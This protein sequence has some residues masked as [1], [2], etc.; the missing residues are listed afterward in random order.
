MRDLSVLIFTVFLTAA[1]YSAAYAASHECEGSNIS[2]GD[3]KCISPEWLCDR[4]K[5]CVDGSDERNCT[6][7]CKEDEFQCDAK[8]CIS[9]KW[10]CDD[11]TDCPRGE[12]EMDCDTSGNQNCQHNE[13]SCGDGNCISKE[14]LCDGEPDCLNGMDEK[15][16]NDSDDL[17][18]NT[19]VPP[20]STDNQGETE[21]RTFHILD[22][23]NNSDDEQH[24]RRQNQRNNRRRTTPY[25]G[26]EG[27]NQLERE[28]RRR[29]RKERKRK[30]EEENLRNG[31]DQSG[32]HGDQT[33]SVR[34]AS[35]V[36]S[37]NSSI[38]HRQT[39]F[40]GVFVWC[41]IFVLVCNWIG[42]C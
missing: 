38:R 13:V 8:T 27:N 36:R 32:N 1:F 19:V 16:C 6:N 11:E 18:P 4:Q 37:K 5:D 41:L 33:N 35:G 15:S 2:C 23:A 20:V 14:W 25:P 34:K 21:N 17:N 26:D 28:E 10:V 7:I 29:Q 12:D 3:G 31:S 22:Q 9:V 42:C 39:M 24:R 30:E 40:Q